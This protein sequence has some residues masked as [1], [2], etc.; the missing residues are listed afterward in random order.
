M[1]APL[2]RPGIEIVQEFR[3][4]SP[5]IL[6]PAL[7]PVVVGVGKQVVD[8][9]VANGS[10]S[11][12]LNSDAAIIMPGSFVAT[13]APGD[14]PAYSDLNGKK[15]VVSYS[16]GPAV[17]T[18][19]VGTSL[20][21]AAV[22]DQVNAALALADITGIAASLVGDDQWQLRT[23]GVGE[24]QFIDVTSATEAAVAEAFGIGIGR[25]YAGLNY[26][27]QYSSDISQIA[28]PDPR[29]NLE[30]LAIEADTIRAFVSLGNSAVRESLRDTA[31]CQNGTG[32][33][34]AID[35]GNGD[36]LT[37]LI[38]FAGA[39]FTASPDAAVVVGSGGTYPLDA[40]YTLALSDGSQLQTI[41]LAKDLTLGGAA[42]SVVSVINAVM[43][44]TYG[45][46]ITADDDGTGQLELTHFKEGTDSVIKIDA[47]S[48][49][50][51]RLGLTAG[52]TRGIPSLPEPGDELW[53]DG[54]FVATISEVAPGAQADVLRVATQLT[55]QDDI[56]S[57]YYIV[58]K[59]L[60]STDAT[61]PSADLT[62]DL[63]G[64]VLLKQEQL[65]DTQGNPVATVGTIYLA[66]KAVREDITA[67]AANAGLLRF[68]DTTA[69]ESA[70]APINP[71]NPLALGLY[72]ALLNAPGVQVTGLG[73]DAVS[74]DSPYGTVEAFTRAAEYLEAYEVYAIAPLTHEDEVHQV[75]GAHVTALSEPAAKGERVV[76]INPSI[77][78]SREA[79]LVASG[80]D[81]NTVGAGGLTFNT[82][83]AN[84]TALVQAAGITPIGTIATSEGLY[85]DI[86]SD[87]KKYS[88][89][90]IS[91]AIITIRKT[92]AAGENDD[93]FYAD[94]DLNDSPL[95]SALIN[96]NFSIK[97]RGA[98]LVVAGIVDKTGMAETIATASSAYGNRRVWKTMPDRCAA[99]IEGSEQMLEG[100]YMN[101]AIAGMVGANPPQQSFTNFPIAGF[102]RVIGS[103]NYF[104]ESQMNVM[105]GGG[106]WIIIQ[107]GQGS[108]LTSRMALTTDLTSIETR[109]D[110]ITKV[111]DYVSKM[112]RTSL[113]NFIG[114]FNITQ[115]F[116]DSL[117]AVI[118]GI[119]GMLVETGV[120]VGFNLNNIIQD[121]DAPD[122]VLVDV[123]L[124]VPY[125][126]NYLRLVLNI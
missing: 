121:E 61:R 43:S 54:A 45:G 7:I 83:V 38:Q 52:T 94:T 72:F 34:D 12:S 41:N 76:L 50:L 119:G 117:G 57:Y 106:T 104:N 40:A 111:V 118:Q 79:T 124:D 56:G 36:Q 96:E 5:T 32:A 100:F 65:I 73:V 67:L 107:E 112:L 81:G 42:P 125:P 97:I 27:N 126:C 115:G 20:T 39:D 30:E 70:L 35:D 59:N 14:P 93:S 15:L 22:V 78:T 110:S 113:R 53:I 122:T 99:T 31:F 8:L 18:T 116:L 37:S 10:G 48:T 24:F 66:Y 88:I 51:T 68:D 44:P 108:P 92:F 103:N 90:G 98:S 91:G 69:L 85:L 74:E 13:A 60:P 47:S 63:V 33:I 82:N 26:Y 29:G 25:R 46:R 21:P 87:A 105:A 80:L 4:V 23:L 16:N 120:L 123:T 6:T 75:L 19:F 11:S 1:A 28:F 64:N 89:A 86:A 84:L 3:S 114:R 55:I 49:G 95:P 2:P 58:A 17:T 102:S 71:D 101:A 77:P 62:V 109:T 9:M